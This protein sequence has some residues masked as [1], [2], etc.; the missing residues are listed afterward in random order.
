MVGWPRLMSD[1]HE[2]HFQPDPYRTTVWQVIAG[3]LAP[4][5][6]PD[7]SVVEIGAGYCDWI[8]HVQA[9]RRLAVDIWPGVARFAAPGVDTALLDA[10]AG[11]RGLGEGSFDVALASNVLEHFTADVAGAI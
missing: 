6:S 1:Y 5:V 8:N 2:A 9:A 11:L 10:A 4:W 3:H 7:A